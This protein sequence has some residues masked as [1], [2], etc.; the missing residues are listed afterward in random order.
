MLINM[1][2]C[3]KHEY[4]SGFVSAIAKFLAH[5][6]QF[7]LEQHRL[8]RDMR[9][10]GASD[11]LIDIEYPKD[12]SSSLKSRIKRFVSEVKSVRLANLS[13]E[14]GNKLFDKAD[15]I[16]QKIDKQVFKLKHVCANFD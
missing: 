2:E 15:K 14:E 12:I 8:K 13:V 7:L 10:I 4:N 11:H 6:H 1:S 9:I 16:L 3:K 5:R